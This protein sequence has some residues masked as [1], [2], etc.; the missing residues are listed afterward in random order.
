MEI[1]S[2]IIYNILSYVENKKF[3]NCLSQINFHLNEYFHYKYNNIEP[4]YKYI[5]EKNKIKY[6]LQNQVH[7]INYDNVKTISI[8]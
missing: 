1:S 2:E 5:L 8:G 7:I 6:K 4:F 3:K